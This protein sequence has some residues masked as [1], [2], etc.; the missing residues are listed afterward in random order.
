MMYLR[1]LVL[2][3]KIALFPQT[4]KPRDARVAVKAPNVIQEALRLCNCREVASKVV[5]VVVECDVG[6]PLDPA[7]GLL[8]KRCQRTVN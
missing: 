8:A 3:I 1:S 5:I 6:G 4:L 2:Y 7:D